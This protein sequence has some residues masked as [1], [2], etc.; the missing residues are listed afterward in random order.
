MTRDW[1]YRRTQLGGGNQRPG[2]TPG[3]HTLTEMLPPGRSGAPAPVRP[4]RVQLADLD[5]RAERQLPATEDWRSADA[6]FRDE[7]AT[8]DYGQNG[9]QGKLTMSRVFCSR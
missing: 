1:N 5:R 8:L 2:P 7:L 3:K 4:P 6:F 9:R